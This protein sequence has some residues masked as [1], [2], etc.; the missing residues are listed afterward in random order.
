MKNSISNNTPEDKSYITE[1]YVYSYSSLES[2]MEWTIGGTYRYLGL[3]LKKK[4][5]YILNTV[6]TN[7]SYSI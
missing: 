6:I 3:I 5:N 4:K 1:Y 7:T 2:T